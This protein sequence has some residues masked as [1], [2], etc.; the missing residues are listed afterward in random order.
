MLLVDFSTDFLP[1]TQGLHLDMRQ[2][3][4]FLDGNAVTSFFNNPSSDVFKTNFLPSPVEQNVRQPH[5]YKEVAKVIKSTTLADVHMKGSKMYEQRR[6]LKNGM[7][8]KIFPDMVVVPKS[9]EDVSKIIK[10]ASHY[11]TPI[12]VRSGG[13]SYTCQSVKPGNIYY[14]FYLL[15]IAGI[16][17][18]GVKYKLL[19][20]SMFVY[21]I[22]EGI[23]IDMRK[24]NKVQ[25]ATRQPFNHCPPGPAAILGPGSTWGRVLKLI[26]RDRFTMVHGQCTEVHL[27]E[28]F[29]DCMSY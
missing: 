3:T 23:F 8:N 7:C 15:S 2:E 20:T 4:P 13:H 17:F 22:L 21:I 5:D 24:M 12:S 29:T 25:I 1:N 6:K 19:K 14:F 28:K 9:T 27:E 10:T 11:H 18:S 16:K 26:P